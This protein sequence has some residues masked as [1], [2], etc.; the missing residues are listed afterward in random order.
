MVA[1]PTPDNSTDDIDTHPLGYGDHI[2]NL[3]FGSLD[4]RRSFITMKNLAILDTPFLNQS[5]GLNFFSGCGY[6]FKGGIRSKIQ[7]MYTNLLSV[8]G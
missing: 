5:C 7:V 3:I 8:S 6:L 4:N 1:D 2:M